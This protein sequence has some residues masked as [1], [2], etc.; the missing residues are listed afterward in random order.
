MAAAS[1]ELAPR[2][3]AHAVF[4]FNRPR[5]HTAKF[6][7][8]SVGFRWRWRASPTIIPSVLPGLI[9]FAFS[10]KIKTACT[11]PGHLQQLDPKIV[12]TFP[13]QSGLRAQRPGNSNANR[14]VAQHFVLKE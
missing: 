3:L 4:R 12:Y 13:P 9:I 1:V 7:A 10:L 11:S 8:S 14:S 5:K 2:S 6:N